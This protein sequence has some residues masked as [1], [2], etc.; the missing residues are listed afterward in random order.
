M[1][2]QVHVVD[3]VTAGG[4]PGDQA[5]GLDLREHPGLRGDLNV[6]TD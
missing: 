3:A 4:H 5:V 1:A 2:Q 6:V